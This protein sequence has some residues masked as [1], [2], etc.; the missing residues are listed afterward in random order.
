MINL[1]NCQKVYSEKTI[2][3]KVTVE[4]F[5]G[6]I[7]SLVGPSGTGKSTLLRC[8]AGLERL[9]YGD[10][11]V[12]GENI[13]NVAASNRPVVMM[14]QQSL[15]FP[16]M[17]V[18]ENVTYGLKMRKVKKSEPLNAGLEF[19]EKVEMVGYENRFPYELSG[20]QQ[21]RVSLARALIL[22]PKLLLLDE[23]FSSLDAQLRSTLRD[24]VRVVLKQEGMTAL[25]VTHDKEEA[26]LM[27]D[28]V[29]VLDK[30]E[31][32]QIGTP[33]QVYS[34]P[35]NKEVAQFFSEGIVLKNG[36]FAPL[37]KLIITHLRE[38]HSNYCWTGRITKQF[39]KYGQSFDKIQLKEIAKEIIVPTNR[40]MNLDDQVTITITEADI[41][42]LETAPEGS[43]NQ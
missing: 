41:L 20:G 24:W 14:F 35:K 42:Q 21:Q 38:D 40:A 25:F 33:D 5:E 26:M 32:Q 39:V 29:A 11:F 12:G 2:F 43:L 27:G 7:V 9:T 18:L 34:A 8:I 28:R 13:T 23:P 1:V 30:G 6:E 22:K 19:L 10:V 16:H 37:D 3:K 15:L 4:I 17:T 36:N 31:L